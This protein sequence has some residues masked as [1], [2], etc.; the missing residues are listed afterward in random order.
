MI[1]EATER[2]AAALK[3]AVSTIFEGAAW[4][5]NMIERHRSALWFVQR[6]V[7][8]LE[9]SGCIINNEFVGDSMC[10][11]VKITGVDS[12]TLEKKQIAAATAI[13][14]AAITRDNIAAEEFVPELRE[15]MANVE[16]SVDE[17]SK[18]LSA[19]EIQGRRAVHAVKVYVDGGGLSYDDIENLEEAD[20][21]EWLE[22]H[23][24]PKALEQYRVLTDIVRR[25]D[26]HRSPMKTG[27]VQT[28]I[29]SQYEASKIVRDV[30]ESLGLTHA[31]MTG[32]SGIVAVDTFATPSTKLID[33]VRDIN[34]NSLRVFND[35]HG[36]RRVKKL[37]E[38]INARRVVGTLEVALEYIGAQLTPQYKNARDQARQSNATGYALQ[39]KRLVDTHQPHPRHP[40]PAPSPPPPIITGVPPIGD[41]IGDPIDF[42]AL[43]KEF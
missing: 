20:R 22:S 11:L 1:Q 6:M 10:E 17:E 13:K 9:D 27:E 15:Y 18:I 23:A 31:L 32:E 29:T 39:W 40:T 8:L 38:G 36:A 12:K 37:A 33:I 41:P 28:A 4:V 21:A 34:K 26:K 24:E 5:S 14:K 35:T 19:A 7:R 16:S 3:K 30:C 2:D 42:G 25:R 43:L